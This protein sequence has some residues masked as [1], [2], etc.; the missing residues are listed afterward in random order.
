MFYGLGEASDDADMT[1]LMTDLD[2]G[3]RF[4]KGESFAEFVAER[5]DAQHR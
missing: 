3:I 5:V 1:F 4:L 2:E